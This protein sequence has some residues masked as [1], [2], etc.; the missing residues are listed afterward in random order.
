MLTVSKLAAHFG[1]SRGTL[2]YYESI[3][4]LKPAP[5]TEGN[6]RKYGDKDMERLRQICAYRDAGL[7]LDDIRTLLDQ[8]NGDAA[9]VLKHRLLALNDEIERLRNHQRSILKLLQTKHSIWR[10]KMIDKEKWVS[11]M[12]AS[13][14]T[15]DDM[16]RWHGEF[17]NMAPEEHQEFLQFLHIPAE[18]IQAIREWSA[19]AA[20][21]RR[22]TD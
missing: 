2:L 3:G 13:G 19:K 18:E 16:H 6:Y 22:H 12:K 21:P 11:I 17:E 7:T 4:L 9:S 10:T 20:T 8:P 15:E 5:R 1:L 14:F